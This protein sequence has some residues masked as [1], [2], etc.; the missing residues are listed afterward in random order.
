MFC[1]EFGLNQG[2]N[3]KP[4]QRHRASWG[5]GRRWDYLVAE[6]STPPVNGGSP[7]FLTARNA[8][9][10]KSQNRS[11]DGGAAEAVTDQQGGDDVALAEHRRGPDQVLDVG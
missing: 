3:D 5:K 1:A 11:Q 8:A 2:L 10:Q 6:K 4:H 9:A 7:S